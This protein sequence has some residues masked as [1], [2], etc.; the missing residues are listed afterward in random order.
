VL[1]AYPAAPN[2][3]AYPA[4]PGAYPAA[5]TSAGYPAALKPPTLACVPGSAYPAAPTAYPAVPTAYP[6][7]PLR[8]RHLPLRTRQPEKQKDRIIYISTMKSQQTSSTYQHN[9]TPTFTTSHPD[10]STVLSSSPKARYVLRHH[11]PSRRSRFQAKSKVADPTVRT[12]QPMLRTRHLLLRTR[13]LLL[14]TRHL[15]LRTR[16]LLL[17][18]RH[19]LLRTRQPKL[20]TSPGVPGTSQLR[21][22]QCFRRGLGLEPRAQAAPTYVLAAYPAPPTAY[23]ADAT[24]NLALRTRHL[25]CVPGSASVEG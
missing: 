7:P 22:R 6:A 3:G 12:R 18:T 23:P 1:G 11:P 16:H 2:P 9:P 10:P 5:P 14:R 24:T 25:L 21:T 15:L 17:R 20:Q 4:A 8:T 13:H 19:L